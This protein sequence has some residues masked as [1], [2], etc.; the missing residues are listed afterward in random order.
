[1]AEINLSTTTR[2][3]FD[4]R[5]TNVETQSNSDH[6]EIVNA[7]GEYA[8]L[9]EAIDNA[10]GKIFHDWQLAQYHQTQ[11]EIGTV[12]Y[13]YATDD[14]QLYING[15]FLSANHHYTLAENI[16]T[17]LNNYRLDT[18]DEIEIVIY[19]NSKGGV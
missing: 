1:M 3:S 9:A 15:V 13:N 10:G 8:N 19:K 11:I 14:V 16:I 12:G 6:Q 7:R 4:T 17:L 5:L 2:E 18:N